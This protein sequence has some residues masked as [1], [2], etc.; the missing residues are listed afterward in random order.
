MPNASDTGHPINVVCLRTG[1]KFDDRY[2]VRLHNMVERNLTLPHRFT[3]FTDKPVSGVTCV[4]PKGALPGWWGKLMFFQPDLPLGPGPMLY[5]DLDMV[6]VG[7]IDA[8]A[9][10]PAEFATIRQWKKICRKSP[11]GL[12]VPMY[13]TSVMYFREPGNRPDVWRKGELLR[14]RLRSDQDVLAQCYPGEATFPAKWFQAY[15]DVGPDGPAPHTK[16]TIHNVHDNHTVENVPWV[17][18]HWV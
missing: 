10:Y 11:K 17:K 9:T 18:K 4:R 15:E 14:T 7:N 12:A 3:C 6:I 1:N 13:N 2:V 5:F 16:V 8:L